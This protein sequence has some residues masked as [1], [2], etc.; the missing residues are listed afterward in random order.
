MKNIETPQLLLRPLTPKDLPL[1]Y[2]YSQEPITQQEL[3]DEVF[4][5]PEDCAQAV[6]ALIANYENQAY[7]LVYGL[8]LKSQNRLI[9]HISLSEIDDG[10]EIGYA[11]ATSYQKQGYLSEILPAFLAWLPENLGLRKL[12]GIAKVEN[13][14]SRHLLEKNGFQKIQR[15]LDPRYFSGKSPVIIYQKLL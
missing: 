10:L 13:A 12:Y 8:V 3:P 2:Q 5:T 7:P 11:V 1:L 6:S 15:I 14:A 9:G 4:A